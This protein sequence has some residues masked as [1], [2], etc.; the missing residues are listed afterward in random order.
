MTKC[1]GILFNPIHLASGMPDIMRTVLIQRI[2]ITLWKK[3][4]VG[5]DYKKRFSAMP[6]ALDVI[7]VI[8]V[9]ECLRTNSLDPVIKDV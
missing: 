3:A 9:F 7:I 8:R 5:Q 4:F 1:A 2:Q 6:F